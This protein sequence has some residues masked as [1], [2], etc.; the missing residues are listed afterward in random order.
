MSERWRA[1]RALKSVVK[2]KAQL[3]CKKMEVANA[4]RIS[5]PI[6]FNLCFLNL[7]H[8]QLC[9][10][11]LQSWQITGGSK[12]SNGLQF[13]IFSLKMSFL[14]WANLYFY[15]QPRFWQPSVGKMT[16]LLNSENLKKLWLVFYYY[17]IQRWFSV[18][19]FRSWRSMC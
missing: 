14:V 9:K 12:I 15:S 4:L 17:L 2:V 19:G 7:Q 10:I 8:S 3:A 5:P 6:I 1:C 11:L 16:L 18:D 13:L